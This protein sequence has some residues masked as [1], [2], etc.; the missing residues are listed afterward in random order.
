MAK[1]YQNNI[2]DVGYSLIRSIRM[3]VNKIIEQQG[4]THVLMF[5]ERSPEQ[6]GFSL[7]NLEMHNLLQ[8]GMGVFKIRFLAH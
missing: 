5:L 4:H 8:I 6:Y 7:I 1:C 3:L 2:Y